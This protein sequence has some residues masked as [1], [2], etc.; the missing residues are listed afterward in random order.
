MLSPPDSPR[1]K[2]LSQYVL[3]RIVR[4]DDVDLALFDWDRHNT[5]Y[6]FALNADERIYLRYGGRDSRAVQSYLDLESIELALQQGLAL[7]KRHQAGELPPATRPKP[8]RVQD[9]PLLVER[10]TGRG[11]CVECHLTM[12]YQNQHRELDGTFDPVRHLY[13]SPDIKTIGID[14]DVP[15]GLVV[16]EASGAVAA[17]GM[18]AGDRITHLNG[19]PVYTFA[20][21]QYVYDKV[22]RDAEGLQLRVQRGEAAPE[23]RVELPMRWWFTDLSYRQWSMEPRVPFRS[24]PLDEA[25]KRALGLNPAGFASRVSGVD[26]FVTAGS[27]GIE[28]GDVIFSVDGRETD[29]IANTAELFIKLRIKAGESVPLSLLRGGEKIEMQLQTQRV[30]FRK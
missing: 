26:H 16:R 13:R 11:A 24:R 14:L 30:N 15:R 20:D 22:D 12:D 6:Y 28:E 27:H 18:L 19:V 8:L 4:L 17:A 3:A 10:T 29:E 23:L 21:L 9:F 7:H 2:L 25:E 1:G 5:L